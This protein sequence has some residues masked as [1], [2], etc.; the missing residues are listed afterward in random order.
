MAFPEDQIFI[1]EL[2]KKGL[3]TKSQIIQSQNLL[4]EQLNRAGI[5]KTLLTHFKIDEGKIARSIAEIFNIPFMEQVNGLTRTEVEEL[6]V[7]NIPEEFRFIPV[8]ADV[9]EITIAIKD[10]PYQ[11]LIDFVKK[12]TN[13]HIIPIVLK[14][15]DF[16]YLNNDNITDKK[17]TKPIQIDFTKLDVEKQGEQ[18]AKEAEISGTLPPAN[19]VLERLLETARET[20]ASDIHFE[21]TS[22]RTL[23]I[24]FRLD[25][26]LQ[27]VVTLPE[28]YSSSLIQ[29][30]K[31]KASID[32]FEKKT[33]SEGQFSIQLGNKKIYCRVNVIPTINAEKIALRIVSQRLE[34]IRLERLGLSLHDLQRIR[35]LLSLPNAVILLSGPAGSG[36]TTTLYSILSE[37]NHYTKNITSVE[38]PVEAYLEGVNQIPLSKNSDLDFPSVTRALFHH[39]VDIL[40]LG[41]IRTK[42]EANLLLEAGLSGMTAF[43]TIQASDA[44]K[45]IYRLKNLGV[46]IEQL[47]LVLKGVISQRFVRKV[48]P[49]CASEYLPEPELLEQAGLKKLPHDFKLKRGLGCKNCMGTG[50][51]GR[52]PVFEVLILNE[53]ISSLIYQN[54]PHREIIAAATNE[55]FTSLRYDGLRKALAGITTLNEVLRVT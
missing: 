36:K 45:T 50:Y 48:C 37:L 33:A 13:K 1:Q 21:I 4:R 3:L 43:A 6:D 41:E 35:H 39:D 22:Q 11:K 31:Q 5:T 30:I 7:I 9:N 29:I 12:A 25:G 19:S 34:I 23:Q 15:S 32:S 18:W 54:K 24:R 20:N 49:Y 40:S 44:I 27:R 55:G 46:D 51:L 47:A 53:T 17:Q 26:V 42:Q 14:H 38:N 28:I 2:I 16:E 8:L 52:I 10:P